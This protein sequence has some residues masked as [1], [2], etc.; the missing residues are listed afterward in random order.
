MRKLVRNINLAYK[1][2]TEFTAAASSQKHRLCSRDDV[3]R[4]LDLPI[5]N[6]TI[7]FF[8]F[9]SLLPFLPL[10]LI[11]SLSFFSALFLSFQQCSAELSLP[12]CL[13]EVIG[14]GQPA[15]PITLYHY[16]CIHLCSYIASTLP[17]HFP[18]LV[19]LIF[20][21]HFFSCSDA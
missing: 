9:F 18:Q 8:F 4:I 10:T 3:C 21:Y 5:C 1:K 7:L 11:P 20:P 17:S 6:P 16:V 2:S 12:V 14:T 19:R 13:P 15:V